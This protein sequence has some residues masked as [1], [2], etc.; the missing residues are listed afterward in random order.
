MKI[1]EKV[2]YNNEIYIY[3]YHDSDNFS[4][5]ELYR[6]QQAYCVSFLKGNE[7]IVIVYNHKNMT[8]RLPGGT[9]E[10]S[11][12]E[13]LDC[14]LKR[15]L[16]EETNMKALRYLPI[17]YQK[18]SKEGSVDN[19]YIYIYIYI[20]QIRYVCI[21]EKIGEFISD[22]DGDITKIKLIDIDKYKEYFN[23]GKIGERI[24]SRANEK[25][26]IIR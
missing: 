13:T 19:G 25:V 11:M 8:W 26:K 2:K 1:T 14:T 9:V 16:I 21:V 18:V 6:C 22:I 23:W 15:E 3:E 7:R 10:H 17:G 20:Y 5:L 24:M 4:S 12:N